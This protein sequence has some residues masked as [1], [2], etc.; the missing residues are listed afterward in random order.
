M[1]KKLF[2]PGA[3]LQPAP[4]GIR[5]SSCFLGLYVA[6]LPIATGLTGLIGSI[7]P[8]NYIAVLYFLTA[9]IELLRRPGRL[10][11]KEFCFIYLYF[12]YTLASFFWNEN[13]EISWYLTTFLTTVLLFLLAASRS[14]SEKEL[15]LFV[16]ASLVSIAIVLA[17][18]AINFPTL[19]QEKRLQI[20]LVSVMDRNDFGCG[21]CVVIALMMTMGL[22]KKNA[23]AVFVLA[24]LFLTVIL[25]SSRGAMLM[26]AV[27]MLCWACSTI[28]I[29]RILIPL[30]PI[31]LFIAAVLVV[32]VFFPDT[33][34]VNERASKYILNRLNLI[35]LLRDGGAGRIYIWRAAFATFQ[36][37]SPLRKIIGFGHASF[38]EAVRFSFPGFDFFTDSHNMY[39]N[40]LIEGGV[41]GLLL[42][43]AAFLQI[44][45]YS[46]KNR[47]LWGTLAVIGFAVEGI[48]LDAQV[49]RIFA[50]VFIVAAIYKGGD[51]YEIRFSTVGDGDRTCL[52]G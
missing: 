27:M 6:L 26:I 12:F 1:L 3:E 52:Q 50:W 43:L 34:R 29:K 45:I 8:L 14:Y 47:N 11:K 35:S 39:V 37:A 30:I 2:F 10:F 22:E 44:F 38:S 41:T 46:L 51:S 33:F 49:F 28:R 17:V 21:L 24:L 18:A 19:E 42:L 16:A 23:W 40:A 9:F 4:E 20:T 36:N 13:R 32:V 7:S 5:I 31:L 25:T 15:K 48:S